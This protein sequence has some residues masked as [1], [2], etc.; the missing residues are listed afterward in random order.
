[1]TSAARLLAEVDPDRLDDVDRVAL[2]VAWERVARWVAARQ[3]ARWSTCSRTHRPGPGWSTARWSSTATDRS[4]P[5]RSAPTSRTPRGGR[6]S[7]TRSPA[8][9]GPCPT[10][11]TCP[12][13]APAGTCWCRTAAA[14]SPAA[15]RRCGPATPDHSRPHH[16]GVCT[17]TDT[18]GCCAAGTTG[19]KPSPAGPGP[20]PRRQC[21]VDRPARTVLG[22]RPR[23]LPPPTP[24][25]PGR[26]A[27][28]PPAQPTGLRAAARRAVPRESVPVTA[29]RPDHDEC[30]EDGRPAGR[31]RST[32]VGAWERRGP[33]LPTW[34]YL[35][36]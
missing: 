9:T 34:A 25:R 8:R 16:R 32:R 23:P 10:A 15:R 21:R 4:R 28:A 11:A 14:C 12:A 31:W 26:S 30:H 18:A 27:R 35:V 6:W 5:G 3:C 29:T 24:T 1:M 20:P 36:W 7:P 13:P 19:S 22:A 2:Q 17:D 33:G